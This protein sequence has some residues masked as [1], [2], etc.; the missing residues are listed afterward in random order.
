VCV[1]DMQRSVAVAG[2]ESLV[3]ANKGGADAS[4]LEDAEGV[5]FVVEE[6]VK[7]L[8]CRGFL[9]CRRDWRRVVMAYTFVGVWRKPKGRGYEIHE[10]NAMT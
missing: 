1:C 4:V 3:L 9:K 10:C 7:L 8:W 6:T 2:G 5:V